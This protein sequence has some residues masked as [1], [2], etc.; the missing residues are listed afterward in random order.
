[1][2]H[3]EPL[4]HTFQA[5]WR[6]VFLA[7]WLK[8]PSPI[9]PDILAVDLVNKEFNPRT[10]ELKSTRL[11][12]IEGGFPS[13][14][15]FLVGNSALVYF[16]EES[17]VNM[18]DRTFVLRSKNLNFSSIITVT[19]ECKYTID[20]DNSL[21]THFEQVSKA[22]VSPS[23][24]LFALQNKVEDYCLC[25]AKKN[26]ATGRMVM[27]NAIKL[28]TDTQFSTLFSPKEQEL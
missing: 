5:V 21:W 23:S 10:N 19:E 14:L 12:T 13:W 4:H 20:K 7:S 27:D 6:D 8:F 2:S 26:A 11:I 3:S 17:T 9:R 25:T 18:N 22:E 1:M 24:W 28:V 16:L 15:N